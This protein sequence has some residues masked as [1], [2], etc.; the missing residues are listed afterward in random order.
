MLLGS[1]V[2]TT[3][4]SQALND[5]FLPLTI[6]HNVAPHEEHV[7]HVRAIVTVN[8]KRIAC[9][10]DGITLYHLAE[11]DHFQEYRIHKIDHNSVTLCRDNT[12]ST[13][14]IEQTL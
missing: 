8:D 7:L 2:G 1:L 13:L 3:L 9:I 14:S 4:T 10:T 12:L 6:S 5:P 11:G